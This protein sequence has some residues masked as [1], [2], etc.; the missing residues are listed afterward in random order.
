MAAALPDAQLVIFERS[1]HMTF[2]EENA[3]YVAAVRTFL[4]SRT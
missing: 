4:T 2:V 3:D 1:G